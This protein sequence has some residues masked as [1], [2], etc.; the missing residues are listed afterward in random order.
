MLVLLDCLAREYRR[1]LPMSIVDPKLIYHRIHGPESNHSTALPVVLLHGLMGFSAN[2]GKVWP[3]L[4]K[5]RSVLVLDQRGHGKSPKPPTGYAPSDYAR[6]LAALLD[7]LQWEKAHIVGH[8]MGGRVAMRFASLF[9]DRAVSLTMEDSGANSR[10]ERIA[11]IRNLLS[12][13]PTPFPTREE[14]R[15]FFAKNFRDD[16]M[17]GGFLHANLEQKEN[18]LLDWRFHAPG[19]VE[20]IETGRATDAM[21]EF[22]KLSLP[23]LLIRG[24]RSAEFPAAEATAMA[25]SRENVSLITIE[26]AGHFVHAEKPQ[27]FTAA[28]IQF[29]ERAEARS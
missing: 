11:W 16:P 8:S 26:G 6:D 27:E 25:E 15:D 17:T 1:F 22:S 3:E 19:M 29:L 13:V 18:G 21:P 5:V 4:H 2:W 20:T 10:P 12:S 24:G 14:A 9:P 7:L 28:L 23:T